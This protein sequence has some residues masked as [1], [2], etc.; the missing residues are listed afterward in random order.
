[1]LC[2]VVLV[3][4]IKCSDRLLRDLQNTIFDQRKTTPKQKHNPRESL[5]TKKQIN[6]FT[7]KKKCVSKRK[8]DQMKIV[9]LIQGDG[10][11]LIEWSP[12]V[13]V[14]NPNKALLYTHLH[15]NY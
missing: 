4:E 15:N 1:V 13:E 5:K 7:Q 14:T 3:E 11:K 2:A 9:V 8:K 6:S 10:C 12:L